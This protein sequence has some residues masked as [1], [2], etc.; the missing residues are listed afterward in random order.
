MGPQPE[1][2]SAPRSARAPEGSFFCQVGGYTP[3]SGVGR[4]SPVRA[5][6]QEPLIDNACG[7][8]QVSLLLP[9]K[10]CA[11]L[12]TSRQ[13]FALANLALD[14]RLWRAC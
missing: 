1:A 10:P 6:R 8:A 2:P 13:R 5:A 3:R 12:V 11:L 9:P 7:A 14:L 4:P